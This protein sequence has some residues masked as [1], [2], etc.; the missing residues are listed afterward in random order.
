[1]MTEAL[2]V[3]YE[4]AGQAP[5][6]RAHSIWIRRVTDGATNKMFAER[7][8]GLVT[9]N[10]N[11]RDE[12]SKLLLK[13]EWEDHYLSIGPEGR[14]ELVKH[15]PGA[16]CHVLEVVFIDTQKNIDMGKFGVEGFAP[17]I[18]LASPRLDA[19]LFEMEQA[20][21]EATAPARL[22]LV[23]L[24]DEDSVAPAPPKRS[25]TQFR[26]GKEAAPAWTIPEAHPL[27]PL[28]SIDCNTLTVLADKDSHEWDAAC[29]ALPEGIHLVER[30]KQKPNDRPPSN[31][32]LPLLD[33]QAFSASSVKVPRPKAVGASAREPKKDN[34]P[35]ENIAADIRGRLDWDRIGVESITLLLPQGRSADALAPPIR[36]TLE[37]YKSISVLREPRFT[38]LDMQV[39]AI[40]LRER[41]AL[42]SLFEAAG[43]TE[44]CGLRRQRIEV[45]IAAMQGAE[46]L[47]NLR[48]TSVQR[49]TVGAKISEGRKRLKRI[50]EFGFDQLRQDIALGRYGK[51]GDG[52]SKDLENG[53]IKQRRAWVEECKDP[54][55]PDSL[56]RRFYDPMSVLKPSQRV[57]EEIAIAISDRV[58]DVLAQLNLLYELTWDIFIRGEIERDLRTRADQAGSRYDHVPLRGTKG[59]ALPRALD[60]IKAAK[61]LTQLKVDPEI[62]RVPA[63]YNTKILTKSLRVLVRQ[64]TKLVMALVV[65][66]IFITS[67]IIQIGNLLGEMD[68]FSSSSVLSA[69]LKIWDSVGAYLVIVVLAPFVMALF[70]LG[71]LKSLREVQFDK[72]SQKTHD[73]LRKVADKQ[74][75]AARVVFLE[76][77]ERDIRA[78]ERQLIVRTDSILNELDAGRARRISQ[79]KAVRTDLERQRDEEAVLLK[80][81][82]AQRSAAR[83]KAVEKIKKIFVFPG[84]KVMN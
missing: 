1:M 83:Q 46:Q 29:A 22:C 24:S 69:L 25:P 56:W 48:E 13:E 20:I 71:E 39:M 52:A 58:A 11:C 41:I 27:W 59:S 2:A 75:D 3:A 17:M 36:K 47:A 54:T 62:N 15:W 65:F 42:S 16:F 60:A 66:D 7:F 44:G 73:A 77:V 33:E 67:D 78:L 68:L 40:D 81:I 79:V 70:A 43:K 84:L 45:E 37:N 34:D 76:I 26:T 82:V 51:A 35:A 23:A 19:S 9:G 61:I 38:P 18:V 28:G 6:A 21:R 49:E 50:I 8:A 32:L 57:K 14:T 30:A 4:S 53:W 31:V 55:V 10:P 5:A 64:G 12:I 74:L 63:R 80:A 72:L